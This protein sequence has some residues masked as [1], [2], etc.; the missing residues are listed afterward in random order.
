MNKVFKSTT[1]KR[2]YVGGVKL[3]E[4]DVYNSNASD[5]WVYVYD[6]EDVADVTV[7]T[8]EPVYQALVPGGS[9]DSRGSFSKTLSIKVKKGLIIGVKTVAN[10]APSSNLEIVVSYGN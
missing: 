5:C 3:S 2:V 9:S 7:G 8:T 6:A 4:I 1:K 10:T